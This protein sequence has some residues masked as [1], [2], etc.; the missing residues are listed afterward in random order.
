MTSKR[1]VYKR[2]DGGVSVLIPSPTCLKALE[3]GGAIAPVWMYREG[4]RDWLEERGFMG[5]CKPDGTMP[6]ELA[7][8]W[9][10]HKFVRSAHWRPDRPDREKIATRWIDALIHGGVTGDAA[11][12]L[13]S[14]KDAKPWSKAHQIMDIS[15]LPDWRYR[16][17]W[18]V[19]DN[20]G[21]L[22]IDE[23]AARELDERRAWESYDAQRRA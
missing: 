13:M 23:D 14:D 16:P 18:R 12:W 17:A 6:L 2:Q 10:I 22:W 20:G 1:V 19:S 15:E 9:E 3:R 7:R 4:L 11:L 21:P 8:E 5:K